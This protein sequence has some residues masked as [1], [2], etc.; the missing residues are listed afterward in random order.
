MGSEAKPG[1][2]SCKAVLAWRGLTAD[3]QLFSSG[4]T[5]ASPYSDCAMALSGKPRLNKAGNKKRIVMHE[6][7]SEVLIRSFP[8][9]PS[10]SR[11]YIRL[12]FFLTLGRCRLNHGLKDASA[13]CHRRAA[14]PSAA[15]GTASEHEPLPLAGP[16]KD[17]DHHEYISQSRE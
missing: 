5:A 9:N 8:Q 13:A 10:G 15:P 11:Q 1:V 14:R 12:Y 17:C 7:S 4:T 3:D 2:A 16:A 6:T